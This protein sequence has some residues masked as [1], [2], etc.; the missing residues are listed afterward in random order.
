MNGSRRHP[1]QRSRRR[2]ARQL[3]HQVELRRPHVAERDRE[4]LPL[5]RRRPKWCE[6]RPWLSTSY[7][8]IPTCCSPTEKTCVVS[9]G[10]TRC[11]S[12][13]AHLDDEAAARLEVRRDVAE[14]GD[15][16]RL[17]RQV[18]DRVEDEVGEPERAVGAR[19]REVAD[20]DG[21]VRRRPASRAGGPPS[22]ATARC[23]APRRRARAS[24]SAIRPVP[25][26]SSSARPP[27]ASSAS[28]S[29]TGS[30]TSGRNISA[31]DSS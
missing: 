12:G 3:R 2:H 8:S 13:H 27:P 25:M 16:R 10:G 1:L 23:R 4:P 5:V 22:P 19:R 17:R 31:E 28:R 30:T 9:P 20:R 21:D 14:A 24:G 6:T 29:T 11:S 7:S 26:P 15:L 18:V